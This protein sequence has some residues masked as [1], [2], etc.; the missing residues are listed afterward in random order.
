GQHE[1]AVKTIRQ[2]LA[3][4][5]NPATE[6]QINIASQLANWGLDGEA[7]R[8]YEQV[9][10]DLPKKLESDEYFSTASVAGYVTSL[11]RSEPAP[12]AYQKLERLRAQLAAIADN[13]QDYKPRSIV[14]AIDGAMRSE[15]GKGVI[16]YATAAEAS[17]LTAAIQASI[18][19]LT[20][21]SDAPSLQRYL[22]IGRAAGLVD[23]EEQIQTRLKDAAFEARPKNSPNATGQDSA[24]YNELRSLVTFYERHAAYRRAAEVVAAEFRRDPYKNRFDYQNQIATQYRLAGD[25]GRE[26][27][28][29]RQA[30]AAASGDLTSNYTDW[31]DRYLTLLHSMG[32]RSELQRLASTY[33]AY[34][35]QL[36]NFLVEK[37]EKL[38]A[39][40]AIGSAK[41]T[42]AWVQERSGEVGLLLKDSSPDNEPFF[43][44]ALDI[45]PIGQMLGRRIEGGRALV[46]SDWFVASRN[47]GYWLGLVGREFD[48]RKFILGEIEGHPSSARAQLELAAYYLDKKNAVRAADHVA[49]A[50]ELAPGER[51]VAVMRGAVALANRD[52]K[53]ALDSW[54]SIMTGR[55]TIAAAQSY[56]KVMADNGLL[57]DALPRLENFIVSFVNRA[58][59]DKRSSDRIEAIKPLVREIAARA[60]SDPKSIS[61]VA[62]FFSDAITGMPGDLI[63]GRLL[64]EERLLPENALAVIY[65][66]MHQRISDIAASVLGTPAYENGYYSGSDYIYPARDLADWRKRLIDYLIRARSFDEAR[67]L[68]ATI[69]REQADEE[70]ALESDEQGGSSSENRYDWLPLASALIELRGGRDAATAI[71]ELRRYCGLEQPDG[72]KQ[73]A[74]GGEEQSTH[75]RCLKAYA[76]LIAERREADA[77]ALIYDA[78]SKTARSR[79]SDD[80][81]LAGLAE[82]EARRG[83]GDEASRLLKLLVERST[84][85]SRALLLAAETAARSRRYP[86]AIAFREQ[87]ARANPGDSVNKLELA[88]VM[89]ASGR[90][91]DAVD[92][93]VGLISERTTPNTVRAQGAE[94]LGEIVRA[95][96]SLASRAASALEQRGRNDASA[97]ARSAISEATGNQ[98]EA[99]AALASVNAGPLAAVAQL[100]LGVMALAA[101]REAEAV[102]SLE[103]ALYLDAD[104]Q[105]TSAIAFRSAGP[106]AQLIML[107]GRN[108]RDLAAVRLAE[109]EPQGPQ[110]LI[111]GTVRRALTSGVAGTDAPA[112]L[113]FEPSV[114]VTRAGATGLKTLAEVNESAASNIRGGL[115]ASLVES[116]AKLG[117]YDRAIAI[118]RLRAAEAAKPDERAAIEKRLAEIAV[119]EKSRQLRLALLTRID[120][121]NAIESVYARGVIGER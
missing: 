62:A 49:L 3:A 91:G 53:A 33:S 65:R 107:Y 28:W 32:Q 45:R 27:E 112:T 113:S 34:Q 46:G 71:T 114:D 110:S 74:E 92:Q 77:D 9:F 40:D 96:R 5:K 88:R 118:E 54:G 81:S 98:E 104:D 31:V 24:Y 116:T 1:E 43:K 63:I 37:N 115:L 2:A 100:K 60:S 120:R 80:A 15:F 55:V 21:Y 35:L 95:D 108:G 13:T 86:D 67:L 79:Y 41:Q 117:Q 78:Y 61:E 97:L 8:I 20:M 73:Q 23:I 19:K 48:S 50:S 94:V 59:R 38:L 111:S 44:E 109:G 70:R 68:I 4:K 76:L 18:A 30:Y 64:V 93:I 90:P 82:I 25:Q 57:I 58:S 106:R 101:G 69:K 119:A 85:N 42:R 11:M 83:R 16:D 17:A 56:L 84:D 22:G 7:V 36:I 89:A 12:A 26:L 102:T 87:I 14:Q 47:Y 103:R 72:G 39:L 51:E 29:L 10:A 121:S 105:I 52:R 99:R 66:T 75:E 6:T